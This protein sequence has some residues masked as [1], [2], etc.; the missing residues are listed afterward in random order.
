MRPFL[1]SMD[2]GSTNQNSGFRTHIS[3]GLAGASM[4]KRALYMIGGLLNDIVSIKSTGVN[5]LDDGFE[6]ER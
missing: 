4:F 2:P 3:N 6:N 5:N 1:I